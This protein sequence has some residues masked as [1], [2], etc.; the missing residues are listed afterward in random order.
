M[1]SLEKQ[2][3]Q[4]KLLALLFG[5]SGIKP[6]RFPA[7]YILQWTKIGFASILPP[8]LTIKC[9]AHT[10][11]WSSTCTRWDSYRFYFLF[12]LKGKRLELIVTA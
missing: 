6:P 3:S 8:V 4:A 5:L 11:S 10:V 1:Q 12:S 9:E 2:M 7:L